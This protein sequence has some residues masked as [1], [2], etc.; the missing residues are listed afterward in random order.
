MEKIATKENKWLREIILLNHSF[1]CLL[2]NE[3][4]MVSQFKITVYT[5]TL[6]NH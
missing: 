6:K 5:R 3:V 1:M 4:K 2:R